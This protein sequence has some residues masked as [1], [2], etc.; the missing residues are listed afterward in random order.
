LPLGSDLLPA[1]NHID[2]LSYREEWRKLNEYKETMFDKDCTAQSATR[3]AS[4]DKNSAVEDVTEYSGA[5]KWA[6]RA[7]EWAKRAYL[8]QDEELQALI[9]AQRTM[10]AFSRDE[11]R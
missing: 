7:A 3:A 6:K 4:C 1:F 10:R 9:D 8:T 11:P 2:M 5:A